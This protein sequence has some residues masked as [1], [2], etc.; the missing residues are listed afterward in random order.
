MAQKKKNETEQ[1]DLF[2]GVV[3]SADIV[4]RKLLSLTDDN[5]V[6]TKIAIAVSGALF[7]AETSVLIV[8]GDVDSEPV[9]LTTHTTSKFD[10][11]PA[12]KRIGNAVAR[13]MQWNE[14]SRTYDD[15]VGALQD[16]D[17][18]TLSIDHGDKGRLFT[19]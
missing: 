14:Q 7:K 12:A 17:G 3:E 8:F 19:I 18:W 6:G 11:V 9:M 2:G 16:S 1:V 4:E 10:G 5:P 13:K 15:V